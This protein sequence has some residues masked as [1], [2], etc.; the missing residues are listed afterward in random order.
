MPR[1]TRW[2]ITAAASAARRSRAGKPS[3]RARTRLCTVSGSEPAYTPEALVDAALL[4]PEGADYR[5][6]HALL[7]DAVYASL[8]DD[9]RL[10]LHRRAARWFAGRDPVL[11]AEQLELAGDAAAAA[12][13]RSAAAHEAAQARL[14]RAIHL[15]ERGQALAA[16]DAVREALRCDAADWLLELGRAEPALRAFETAAGS[17][18]DD[19]ARC[20]A[21]TGIGACLRVHERHV[22][23]LAALDRAEAAARRAGLT[24]PHATIAYLRGC[25][26]F[27]LG[28]LDECLRAHEAAARAAA[29]PLDEARAE[30]GLGDAYYQRGDMPAA[31]IHFERCLALARA[32]DLGRVEAANIHM[33]GVTQLYQGDARAALHTVEEAVTRTCELGTP[34]AEL[35]ARSCGCDVAQWVGDWQYLL[36][37]AAPIEAMA[38]TLGSRSF[39]VQGAATTGFALVSLG[40]VDEGLAHLDRARALCTGSIASFIGPTVLGML[41]VAT[42]DAAVRA[43]VLAEAEAQ[44]AAGSVSHNH[45]TFRPLA[46]QACWQAGDAA[47][48]EH[49]RNELASYGI[50]T[51]LPWTRFF[52]AWGDALAAAARG[53]GDRAQ[54][55]RVRAE[56]D[57]AG[58]GAVV[59]PLDAALGSA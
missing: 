24:A 34:R 37:A 44:L 4:R 31:Q 18:Q 28:R 49:H 42:P 59:P 20:R 22:D 27:P 41:A 40:R 56:A 30:S 39:G 3:R 16:D 13:Y 17:A 5:F 43:D 58:F 21:E 26:Y 33:H 57:A 12:A 15:A 55:T 47:G 10:A 23:A 32:H 51:A 29:S 36:Q 25:L 45:L 48:I 11:H 2:P 9:D 1:G 6:A 38:R 14:E 35:V 46:M 19:A 54:L 50:G 7:R 8:L 53:A 52:V